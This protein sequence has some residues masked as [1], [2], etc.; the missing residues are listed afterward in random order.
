MQKSYFL[1]IGDIFAAFKDCE[2][3]Q[4]FNWDQVDQT[5]ENFHSDT[6]RREKHN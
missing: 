6:V 5:S 4:F 2:M 1:V 3:I